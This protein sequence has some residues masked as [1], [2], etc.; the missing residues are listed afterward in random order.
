MIWHVVADWEHDF[1]GDSVAEHESGENQEDWSG[2]VR[3]KGWRG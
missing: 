3:E 2:Q 1:S